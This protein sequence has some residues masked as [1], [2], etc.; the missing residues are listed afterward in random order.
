MVNIDI[1][2]DTCIGCGFC[3]DC[4][5]KIFELVENVAVV[6]ADSTPTAEQDSCQEAVKKC[7][8]NAIVIRNR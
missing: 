8:V 4:C 2:T 1:D 3:V 5:P 6:K 7:P